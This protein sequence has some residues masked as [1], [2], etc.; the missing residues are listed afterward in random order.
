MI[1]ALTFKKRIHLTWH[2]PFKSILFI[3]NGRRRLRPSTPFESEPKPEVGT[4]HKNTLLAALCKSWHFCSLGTTQ[5]DTSP[6]RFIFVHNIWKGHWITSVLVCVLS[7]RPFILSATSVTVCELLTGPSV[8]DPL[9]HF[10]N[11]SLD[12]PITPPQI[13]LWTAHWTICSATFV[14]V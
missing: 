10:R 4:C 5:R 6:I 11:C 8:A 1:I 13:R 12:H 14:S 7:T 3:G 9:F 2:S